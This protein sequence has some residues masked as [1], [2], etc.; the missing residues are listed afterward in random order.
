MN[1]TQEGEE[2]KIVLDRRVF[3]DDYVKYEYKKD[4]FIY[5][6]VESTEQEKQR[7]QTEIYEYKNR[8]NTTKGE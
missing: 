8:T 7:K 6:Q 4:G 3:E 2:F 1:I 5:V